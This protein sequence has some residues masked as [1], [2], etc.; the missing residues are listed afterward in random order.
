MGRNKD[1]KLARARQ[2][3]HGGSYQRHLNDT[4]SMHMFDADLLARLEAE[5][6]ARLTAFKLALEEYEEAVFKYGMAVAYGPTA[7]PAT[8]KLEVS[9][10]KTALLLTLEIP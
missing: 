8:K 10:L 1:Q 5:A 7:H 4:R 6:A 3:E 9:R 2:R